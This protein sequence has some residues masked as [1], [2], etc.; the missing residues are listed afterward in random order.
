MIFR[1]CL[2]REALHLH[3][4]ANPVEGR[5][6]KGRDQQKKAN[7]VG[8]EARCQQQRA[9]E[10]NHGAMGQ[11]LGWIVHFTERLPDVGHGQGT[12]RP[13]QSCT[14]DRRQHDN[15]KRRPQADRS[16]DLH[17]QRDFNQGNPHKK[18]KKPHIRPSILS[19]RSR[20]T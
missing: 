18:G 3:P 8:E 20:W 13:H 16:A 15:S 10:Q 14:D 6:A 17:E 4:L 2:G 19:G 11:W 7:S 1:M 9:R 12:L 5:A